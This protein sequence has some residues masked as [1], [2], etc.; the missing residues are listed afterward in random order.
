MHPPQRAPA[1]QPDVAKKTSYLFQYMIHL[2]FP[3]L[4]LA[5]CFLTTSATAQDP[6]LTAAYPDSLCTSC[7]DWNAPQAPFRIHQEMYYVGPRGLAAILITSPEG[8]ILID[9]GLPDSAPLIM[10]NVR[11]LGFDV[12][13]IKLL[14][15]S[16]THFDHAG[17][18]AAIQ[19]ASGA[20]VLASP[21][22]VPTLA[23]GSSSPDDPQ[24][25][26]LLDFP[27]VPTVEA[28]TPGDTLRV[29]PLAIVPHATAGHAPGGTTWSWRSCDADGCVTVVYADSQTPISAPDFRFTDSA[30]YPT[31]LADFERGF[32]ALEQMSCDIL[33]TT[34]PGATSL[35][36]RLAG[37]PAGL[38]DPEACRRYASTARQRLADRLKAE[39]GGE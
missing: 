19:Q 27:A 29:G 28:F 39:A 10:E 23:R 15:N 20:R 24:Y 11:A 3:L 4:C 14:L 8:H 17:G 9:G 18:L 7:A 2:R 5:L 31:V 6:A 12:A 36:E 26:T 25:G 38:R 37:G 21:A 16:H 30:A 32:Q 22:A 1:A 35:W 33:I 34:H 13:D